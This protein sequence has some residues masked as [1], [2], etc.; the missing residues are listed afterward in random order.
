MNKLQ[1]LKQIIGKYRSVVVAFSGGVDSTFLARVCRDVVGEHLL[2]VTATSST[3]PSFEHQ[4]AVEL[5]K[6][7]GMR[8]RDIVSEEIEIAGFAENTPDRCYYCKREL[9][10][11]LER[12]RGQDGYA[13]VFDGTNADDLHDYRPGSRAAK[14]LGIVSP[15]CE[16]GLRKEDIR[17]Y[18]RDYG[19]PTADKG[20]F[21][22][23]ASRFPYGERITT[24]KLDRV[25][26]AEE[27]LR[28]LGFR[29]FR[30]RSHGDAARVELA[31]DDLARGWEMRTA[32]SRACKEAG[33]VFASL[34]LEGYRTGAMN[35]ALRNGGSHAGTGKE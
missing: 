21:A 20:S 9:F 15:L 6:E 10:G 19:L 35:E 1:E 5:A 34:D 11:A 12:I 18:S 17:R 29:Q 23:L 27:A 14:E 32:L 25:G 7:Y 24:E 8:H 33:F 22:C 28:G 13:V 2:L 30:V 16:A 26:K 31:I 4:Q 3:Y